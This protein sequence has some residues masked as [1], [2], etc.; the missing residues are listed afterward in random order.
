MID[1]NWI[2]EWA[3]DYAEDYDDKVLREIGPRVHQRGHYDRDDLLAVGRWKARGR[4]QSWLN[5][6]TDEEICDITRMALEADLPY[7]HRIMTLLKGVRVPTATALLMVWDPDRHTVIDVNTVKALYD[8]G[9]INTQHL[10]YL[11]YLKVCQ[12]ISG[13]CGRGLRIL[14][15]ALYEYGKQH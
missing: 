4:T 10:S 7:Q 14:D 6:N 9:E 8:R 11:D 1:T 3:A 2:D 15:R 12:Q 5:S 13:R